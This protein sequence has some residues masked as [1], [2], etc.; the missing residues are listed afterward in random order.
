ML[1]SMVFDAKA[2]AS[3][4]QVLDARTMLRL[5]RAELPIKTPF[6]IHASYFP[7]APPAAARVS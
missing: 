7:G 4:F 2:N 5:S 6:L 3:Y 1:L